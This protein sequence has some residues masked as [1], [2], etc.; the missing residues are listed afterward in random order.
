MYTTRTENSGHAVRIGTDPLPWVALCS[1]KGVGSVFMKRLVRRFGGPD[2]VF[3]ATEPELMQVEGARESTV[4]AITSFTGWK[5]AEKE[6]ER[7]ERSGVKL[8]TFEDYNY[9]AN[10]REIHDP[11]H[12]LYVKGTL[13]P[14]DKLSLAIVGSRMAT[15]GGRQLTRRIAR[16]LGARG[17]TI[18]SG[19]ARGVDTEAH[20]G[21][22]AGKGRTISV[23]GCGIDVTY[24]PEN[25]ELY[26]LIA[27]SGAVV[28]E[29]P[30]GTQP[31][32]ANF[33]RR[34]RIISGISLGVLVM[35]ATGDSGSLIT[36]SYSLEQGREVYAVPGNVSSPTS[37]GTNSLLKKGARLVEGAH[38][39][40]ADMFPN[41]KEYLKEMG[42]ADTPASLPVANLEP[43]EKILFDCIGIEPEHV[44]TLVARS[45]ITSSRALTLLLNMELKGA[46]KQLTGMRFIRGCG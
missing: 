17:I 24:P 21:T 46:V 28:S 38:D 39:I 44:D 4:K 12:V 33:P 9:P 27:A 45:G 3:S 19:G 29:F 30:I 35:E 43:E 5:D 20:R 14:E 8:V 34:N 22:L 41:M 16:D 32:A 11:P 42:E 6:V 23:L 25:R 26:E 18:V 7:A 13:I 31:E 10:L 1:V 37:R 15:P 2:A 40:L 36:A